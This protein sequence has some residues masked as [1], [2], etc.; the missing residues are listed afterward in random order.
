MQIV[1]LL[2]S[3]LNLIIRVITIEIKEQFYWVKLAKPKLYCKKKF[4]KIT[5]T[6]FTSKIVTVTMYK[7]TQSF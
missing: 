4:F 3:T 6:S 5:K 2:Y 1:N 7:P